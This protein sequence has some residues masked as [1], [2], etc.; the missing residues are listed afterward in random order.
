MNRFGEN[1]QYY[2]KK[3]NITQEQLAERLQVSRQTVSKWE[4]GNSYAEMDKILQL[5]ELFSCDMDTL[6]RKNAGEAEVEDNERHREHM[7]KYRAGVTFGVTLL[8]GNLA[9]YEILDGV[10]VAE[11]VLD[12]LFM[13]VVIVGVLILVVQGMEHERYTKKYPVIQDFYPEEEKEAFEKSFIKRIATGVG[14]ILFGMLV[15]MNGENLP[16][17]EGMNEE[18]YNGVFLAFV[19][20]AAGIM[21]Y[22]GM[23][24]EEYEVEKYNKDNNPDAESRKRA[25]KISVWCGCIMLAA[26]IIFLVMGLAFTL[27]RICWVVYPV[28]GL[29]CGIAVLIIKKE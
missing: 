9:L 17:H 26:T 11:A 2:R 21:V 28:A 10:G 27:W 5:C 25:H 18:F 15:G 22:S 19:T 8:T 6:L 20:A 24:K 4:A 16:L 14:L 29:L 3:G 12:T 13:A 23:Q 7:K 1:L